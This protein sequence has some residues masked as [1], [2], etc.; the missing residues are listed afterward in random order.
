MRAW[1]GL[2]GNLEDSPAALGHAL[3]RLSS[4]ARID[5]DQVSSWYQSAAW[6]MSDQPDFLNAVAILNTALEPLALLHE[7]LAIEKSLGRV[8]HG[9][10]WGP[11]LVDLDLLTY[12]DACIETSELRLPHPHMHERAFVLIPLIELQSDFEITGR[13]LAK[14]CLA[15]LSEDEQR[16]VTL[17]D[18]N[19]GAIQP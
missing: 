2:G 16:S 19:E 8:R 11:R 7:L 17:V 18:P 5:V 10:R 6:G 9:D 14:D 3:E 15:R 13:G 1:I 4:H 12:E